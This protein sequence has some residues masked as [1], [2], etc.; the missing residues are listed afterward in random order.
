MGDAEVEKVTDYICLGSQ[1][2]PN[3][4]LSG[5]FIRRRRAAWIMFN[6]NH[7]VVTSQKLPLNVRAKIVGMSVLPT[8]LYA[9]ETW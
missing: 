8:M 1:I 2:G 6:N 7:I 3:N 4:I 9:C 5:E